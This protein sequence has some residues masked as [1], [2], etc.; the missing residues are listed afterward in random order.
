M[1]VTGSSGSRSI[2]LDYR[3]VNGTLHSVASIPISVTAW[4]HVAVVKN[5]N[6][7]TGYA[8]GVQQGQPVTDASPNLPN[9]TG[10]TFNGRNTSQF[11]GLLDEFRITASALT[12]AQ[13]LGNPG[14]SS[15]GGL[16]LTINQ[17]IDTACPSD[18]VIVSVTDSS[19]KPVTGLT[20]SNFTLTESGTSRSI[21]VVPV[22][23]GSTTGAVS[24][25][26][27]I[28]A[29]SSL[30]S[31]DLANEK[32]AAKQLVSQ[33]GGSDQAAVYVFETTVAL[34]QDFTTDKTKLNTAIDAI[35]GGSSTALYLAVQTAS[36]A[37]GTKS[38]RKAIVLMT[39]GS[40]TMGGATID[41]AIAAAKTA[42]AP[43]FTVGFG[44]ANQAV[45]TQ[46]ATQTGGFYTGSATSTSLQSILQSIGQ[47]LSS[48][49]EIS[50][51]SGNPTADNPVAITVT[52]NG[53]TST[54]SRTVTKCANSST[55]NCTYFLQPQTLSVP[56]AG[57]T[58]SIIVSTQPGCAVT[59]SANVSW[60]H[61][62]GASTG[63]VSYQIDPN[64]SSQRTGTITVGNR[65]VPVTQDG[66]VTCTY[67]LT[68][69]TNSLGALGGTS[70]VRL[71]TQTGC[72]WTATVTVTGSWFRVT[73]PSSGSGMANL[74]YVAD[75]NTTTSQRTATV[76]VSGQSFTLTQA[77]GAS[78]TAPNIA[79]GG[80]VNAA[81]NRSGTIA[82]GSFFTIYGSNLGPAPYQQVQGYPIPDT[83]GGV[84]V[85]VS[86]GNYNK[87]AFLHFVSPP[88]I[89]AILPSDTPLGNVT[90]TV[91]YNGNVSATATMTVVD[92]NFGTFSTASGPGPGIVQNYNSAAD[93]PLN[94]QSYP[95]KPK[96]IAILWGTGLG[97]IGT[98]DSTP[99]PGG[100]M[101]VPVEVR[102]GGKLANK[103]YSGRAPSFAGVDNI[104]F[105]IPDDAP[106][107]CSVP[108]QINAGG[109]VSNTVRIAISADGKKCQ[110]TASPMTATVVNGAKHGTIGLMR[111]AM[112][113]TI[114]STKP[115]VN[116]TF[117]VGLGTFSN[118]PAGGE[119]AFSP[120][121]NLPP[122]GTCVSS[123][124]PLDAG[125]V[126]ASSGVSLDSSSSTQLD[127]GSALTVSGPNG[128]QKL[129]H[130]DPN[131][132]S[133]PYMSVIG[134]TMPVDGSQTL[135]AFLD[136]GSYTITGAGGKDVG[137]FSAPLTVANPVTWNNAGTVT[138]INRAAGL[139]VSWSG[140]DSSLSVLIAGGSTDQKTKKSGGF[141]CLVPI[142]AGTFTVP[143][144]ILVDLP[145]TGATIGTSDSMGTVSVMSLPLT[146]P[147]GFTAPGLDAGRLFYSFT[148]VRAVPV[149]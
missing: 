78:A 98:G 82:R 60:I 74:I 102:V 50:Y 5:G 88:Q 125:S 80:I 77:G 2:F 63:A 118:T 24:L 64:T 89:N 112:S 46:I 61:I 95:L 18:K 3:E 120:F 103:I 132:N 44:S 92:T 129:Q 54:A 29:S 25:A 106:T 66:G 53:Q 27:L 85:T 124:K 28:D 139:T 108:V 38:G 110:D 22:G 145:P 13:F 100:D 104:Y 90:I 130:F 73:S 11:T 56:A 75:A 58:G 55:G 122:I 21:T 126:F 134:G 127:A 14:P 107:G 39:D 83:M 140:G 148:T 142:A 84:I 6:V 146:S 147:P 43:V 36:L 143:P 59:A 116:T 23:T 81:S 4:T 123:T 141:M 76:S 115:P 121:M 135:P 113:G 62:I 131:A 20:T 93:Q 86:Q 49:Y 17:V 8:N 45:L 105:T 31:S 101:S 37:L 34:K 7:W 70:S 10:W 128:S 99:P 1:G 137:A 119:L 72:T 47:V 42:G 71:T 19:G 149:Q 48:Q 68:P 97:P 96:Q 79:D 26:I 40:D 138:S 32:S 133:G 16:N 91:N 33:L 15:S 111:V 67:S 114:D 94:L 144:N 12:P 69:T 109:V 30:S 9:N 52:Y 65:T 117:D 136:P 35:T 57:V 87:R 41:Q 51:T